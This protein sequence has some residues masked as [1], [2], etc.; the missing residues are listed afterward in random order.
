MRTRAFGSFDPEIEANRQ[1]K[2][3]L[4]L[5]LA[6]N[7]PDIGECLGRVHAYTFAPSD[8]AKTAVVEALSADLHRSFPDCAAILR[9]LRYL[10]RLLSDEDSRTDSA[11]D[12]AADLQELRVVSEDKAS[13]VIQLVERIRA[14][15]LPEFEKARRQQTYASGVLPY[16]ASFG[17]SVELRAVLPKEYNLK[18][19]VEDYRPEVTGLV[20]I[21]SVLIRVDSG[22]IKS[23]A[24]QASAEHLGAFVRKLQAVLAELALLETYATKPSVV[25]ETL[26]AK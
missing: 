15:V 6:M 7:D 2:K 24:F 8:D 26:A 12:W 21:A 5:L 16:L 14:S 3:D 25:T 18:D 9:I 19:R 13:A 22:P 4:E 1:F 10:A 23:L 11:A 17:S 20:P